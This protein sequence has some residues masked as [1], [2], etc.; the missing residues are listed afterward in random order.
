MQSTSGVRLII[1]RL[2]TSPGPQA[3]NLSVLC[4]HEVESAF[5]DSRMLV[6]VQ[7][8]PWGPDKRMQS[9]PATM[10]RLATR[11]LWRRQ[12]ELNSTGSPIEFWQSFDSIATLLEHISEG[13]SSYKMP[14][15]AISSRIKCV[16]LADGIYLC[17]SGLPTPC[18]TAG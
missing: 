1:S 3:E 4:I 5:V 6:Y 8:G 18:T 11:C 14:F 12:A 10:V 15:A 16:P 2:S 7:A 17:C 13:P 9:L